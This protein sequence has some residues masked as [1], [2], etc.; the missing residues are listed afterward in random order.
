MKKIIII[1]AFVLMGVTQSKFTQKYVIVAADSLI[2]LE[3]HVNSF[4]S[5]G[6]V[7]TGGVTV[8]LGDKDYFFQAV[9]KQ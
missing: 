1:L 3:K 5:F 7:P 6:Y 4:L 9:Y 8:M 2:S